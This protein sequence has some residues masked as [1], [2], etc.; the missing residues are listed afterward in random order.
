VRDGVLK[1][2]WCPNGT[3]T[4]RLGLAVSR[5]LGGAVVRNRIKRVLREAF[6][7]DRGSFP[8]GLDLVVIPM[9][10]RRA[11]DFAQARGA[12]RRLVGRIR[13][14]LPEPCEREDRAS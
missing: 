14:R 12:L 2:S 3:D 11:V 4:T 13:D 5:R 6:R 9:D 1:V 10:A 8:P 7:L